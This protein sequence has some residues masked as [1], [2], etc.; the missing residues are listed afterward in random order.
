MV[1]NAATGPLLHVL[2]GRTMSSAWTWPLRQAR[3]N[4]ERACLASQ[5]DLR[6]YL[7]CWP[8]VRGGGP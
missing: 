6:C 4:V 5:Q 7:R 2:S 8:S 3:H 1:R